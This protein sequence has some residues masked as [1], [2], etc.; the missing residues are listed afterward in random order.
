MHRRTAR[1]T[2]ASPSGSISRSACV[3]LQDDKS[4]RNI[5]AGAFL[6]LANWDPSIYIG[7][8]QIRRLA[9]GIQPCVPKTSPGY[10][11]FARCGGTEARRPNLKNDEVG[12]KLGLQFHA[13]EDV[14]IYGSYSRGFKSGKFD[15][16]FL[17]TDDT[18]FPQRPLDPETSTRSSSASSR[19]SRTTRC[20]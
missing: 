7:E 1:S 13:S 20:S 15:L 4:D 3:T 8:E 16:E 12:G 5:F 11:P 10:I 9:A 19:R 17:H 14:M 18:P 2:T 6:K